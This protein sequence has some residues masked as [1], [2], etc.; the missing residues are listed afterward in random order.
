M[1]T[2]ASRLLPS[3]AA[4][5]VLAFAAPVMA[6]PAEPAQP[7]GTAWLNRQISALVERSADK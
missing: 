4:V 7:Q 5:A 2:T 1:F 6:Q 3:L